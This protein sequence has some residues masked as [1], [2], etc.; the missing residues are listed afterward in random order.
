MKILKLYKKAGIIV[1]LLLELV[2]FSVITPHF[3]SVNNFINLLRQIAMLGIASIGIAFLMLGGLSADLSIAGQIPALSMLAGVLMVW[4]GLP[5]GLAMPLTVLGGILLGFFNGMVIRV[6]KINPFVVT[7]ST[8]TI[9]QG[10]ALLFTGGVSIS[11]LPRSFSW[12]GQ[13]N[14]FG[15]P[16]PIIMLFC[17]VAG[18]QFV[19]SK[20]YFGRA[21]YAMG[22]NAEAARL[23]GIN[24]R[25][26]QL[27]CFMISGFF[28]SV[29]ALMISSRT[30]IASPTAG[31]TYAFDTMTA[32]VL[33]GISFAGGEGK[34][35]GAFAGVLIIGVMTNAMTL[36]NVGSYW[37]D[38]IKGVVLI[39]ALFIDRKQRELNV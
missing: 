22:G 13:G 1:F 18:A 34:L 32:C 5:V 12:L 4:L 9:L 8:M 2:L 33:G 10:V 28:A 37:Q 27:L 24:T 11:G 19:L 35:W 29:A 38:I 6:L 23:A 26:M 17:C 36:M 39:L 25:R 16:T 3:F 30:M 31:N 7:L 21:V 20:T 15:I 14:I